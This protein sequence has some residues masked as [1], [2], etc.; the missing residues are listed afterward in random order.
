MQFLEKCKNYDF[1]LLRG[2]TT[3]IVTKGNFLNLFRGVL[4]WV[5]VHHLNDEQALVNDT[6]EIDTGLHLPAISVRRV[7]KNAAA[8]FFGHFL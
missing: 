5:Y 4:L 6:R 1:Y 2:K 8:I 7:V 3:S